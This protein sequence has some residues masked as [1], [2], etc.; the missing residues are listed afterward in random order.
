M[1]TPQAAPLA[2]PP[3]AL[4]E[5][6]FKDEAFLAVSPLS[7]YNVLEYFSRSPFYAPPR[8]G[9][10]YVIV[11]EQEPHLYVVQQ[12]RE[13]KPVAVFFVLDG[14][15]F[16]APPLAAVLRA[17]CDRFEHNMKKAFSSWREAC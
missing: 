10:E 16:Q 5:T 17:R 7:K 12:R 3:L 1:T 8:P 9:E 2:G 15:I 14:S 13:R 4:A 11:E 6:A